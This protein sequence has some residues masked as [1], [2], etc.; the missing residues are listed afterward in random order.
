LTPQARP[1]IR[2]ALLVL[3]CI[4]IVSLYINRVARVYLAQRS[5]G[6]GQLSGVE[7]AIH[8]VPG[9]AE[10]HDLL[11]L[12]LSASD[13]DND[14]AAASLRTAVMLNPNRARYWLDLA[15]VYQVTGDIEKQNEAVQNAL[16]AEPGDAE[17]RAE[18][19]LFFL[20]AGNA[21]RALPLFRQALVQNP[22]AAA[23]ILAACWRETRD[24]NLILTSVIPDNPQLELQFLGM[25]TQQNE[26]SPA[27][28]V[29]QYV[30]ASH[31]PFQPGLSFFYFNYLL[32]EHDVAGFGQAWRDLAGVAPSLQSYLPNENLIVNPG[33]EQHLL[34]SGRDWRYEP[35]DH[36]SAGIDDAVAH[37]GSRALSL[38]YDGNPGYDAGWKQLI[39]V[40]PGA[41]Y[42]LSVWIK[43]E[44]IISSSGPRVA[45]VDAYSGANLLL[46]DDVLDTHPWQELKGTL[47]VPTTI[48]LIAV[49]IIRSPANTRIRGRVWI[50]D[51]RLVKR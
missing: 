43:S 22:E 39:P 13:Q 46:T 35:A 24:A 26:S 4:G 27:R 9:N 31:R 50:D 32:N 49:K 47:R 36:I 25:L 12:Q 18:A 17:V 51:L 44:N 40:E 8:L 14:R 3:V 37:S 15:A 10:F 42:E 7:R 16:D 48:E 21:D 29:W 28:Q 45:I 19:A 33:F 11:G 1:I 30:M 2:K 5:A 20:V 23:T 38:S 6:S 41:E 34:N